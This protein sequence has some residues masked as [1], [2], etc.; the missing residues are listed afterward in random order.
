MSTFLPKPKI[1]LSALP[2][3]GIVTALLAPWV[4]QARPKGLKRTHR[5]ILP[6]DDCPCHSGAKWKH[7]HGASHTGK[8]VKPSR[9]RDLANAKRY[10][11]NLDK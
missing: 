5:K 3:V 6:N 7:C 8:V 1:D 10:L 4:L 2:Q 11:K 9:A